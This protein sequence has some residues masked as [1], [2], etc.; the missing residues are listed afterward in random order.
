MYYKKMKHGRELERE[1]VLDVAKRLEDVGGSKEVV[2]HIR[3]NA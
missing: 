3:K 2:E 1:N